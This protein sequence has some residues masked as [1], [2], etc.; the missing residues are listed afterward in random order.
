M[1]NR[2]VVTVRAR[3]PFLRWLEALPG[4]A[5]ITLDQVNED[6][7]VY[8]LP[9]HE[10]DSERHSLLASYYA[11]IFEDQLAGWW[12][13]IRDWPRSRDLETFSRWFDVEFHSIAV[14]LVRGPLR[15]EE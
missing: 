10:D 6:T 12:T 4:S 11:R 1:L 9:D 2:C 14:D 7:S 8:L 15:D 3:E 13:E 5:G